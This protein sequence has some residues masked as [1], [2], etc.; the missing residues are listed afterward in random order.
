MYSKS[1]HDIREIGKRL[2]EDAIHV[3]VPLNEDCAE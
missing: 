2:K 3:I 1:A